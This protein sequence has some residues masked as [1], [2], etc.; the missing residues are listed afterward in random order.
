M[1]LQ[2]VV[3]CADVIFVAF[4]GPG[5]RCYWR[6]GHSHHNL[7]LSTDRDC[8]GIVHIP[9]KY[10]SRFDKTV[11]LIGRRGDIRHNSRTTF[12]SGTQ[13]QKRSTFGDD[14]ACSVGVVWEQYMA[15]EFESEDDIG[16]PCLQV[17]AGG[18]VGEG[19]EVNNGWLKHAAR[20]DQRPTVRIDTGS[21]SLHH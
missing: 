13:R 18:P 16:S 6:I 5:N 19:S 8:P 21:S 11:Q 9:H 20:S 12:G 2:P 15:V 10:L 14:D 1:D 3:C 17:G 4:E 7:Q